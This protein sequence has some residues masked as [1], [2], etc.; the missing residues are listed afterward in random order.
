MKTFSFEGRSGELISLEPFNELIL[1]WNGYRPP[2]GRWVFYVSLYNGSWSPYIKYAEWG[3]A[4][5]KTFQ[6][7]LSNISTHQD[8][9]APQKGYATGFR[10]VV[11]SEEGASLNTLHNI[12]IFCRDTALFE[13]KPPQNLSSICLERVF[14]HSQMALSHPRHRDLC[15]P[16]S[17]TAAINFLLKKKEVNPLEIAQKVHD[18]EFDIYGNWILNTAAAYE[19]LGGNYQTFVARLPDFTFVHQ[20]LIKAL[21]VIVSVKGPLPGAPLPYER[22]HLILLIG[23]SDGQ[24]LCMD[25]AFNTDAETL[26]SYPLE[27][28]LEAWGARRNLAYLFISNSYRG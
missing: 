10:Y 24:V 17:T 9:I 27:P 11:K 20:Q 1:S 21:P 8:V 18:S 3:A 13:I 5:Q 22:G 19:A 7:S 4:S 25:P 26:I 28:F 15:S 23:Y 2:Q 16:T 6:R 14:P 12:S